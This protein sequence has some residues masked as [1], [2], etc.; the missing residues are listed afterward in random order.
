VVGQGTG[1]ADPTPYPAIKPAAPIGIPQLAGAEPAIVT[2]PARGLV[3]AYTDG[4]IERRDETL[5]IGMKRLA[6][7]AAGTASS[8]EGP[9]DSIITQLTGDAPADDIALIGL[10]WLT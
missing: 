3:L 4:L 7:A 8:L 10:K 2:I 9:A 6:D 1:V 5:D